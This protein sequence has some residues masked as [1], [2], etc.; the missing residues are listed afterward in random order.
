MMPTADCSQLVKSLGWFAIVG[1][2]L[3]AFG[4][5]MFDYQTGGHG[6]MGSFY[7]YN[8][9]WFLGFAA[10][11]FGT[12]IGLLRAWRWARI[13]TLIFSGLLAAVGIL[14]VV[15][16]LSMPAGNVSGGMLLAIRTLSTLFFM[17]PIALGC[18]LL[19]F[20]SRKEVKAYFAR[21]NAEVR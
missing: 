14:G 19:V 12:G 9:I 21:A 1:S 20:F 7:H 8:L 18:S 10:W 4:L 15:A 17:S 11:S 5:L 13:S 2:A 6:E 16:F 3:A